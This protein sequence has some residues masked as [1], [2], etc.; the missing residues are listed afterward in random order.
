MEII[1]VTHD[2]TKLPQDVIQVLH[3]MVSIY[4]DMVIHICMN[5]VLSPHYL[6]N[7]FMYMLKVSLYMITFPSAW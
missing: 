3:G 6:V 5:M 4:Y 1:K 7:V 2:M